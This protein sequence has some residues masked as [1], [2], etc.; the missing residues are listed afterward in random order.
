MKQYCNEQ[1]FV[2]ETANLET[3]DFV[4]HAECRRSAAIASVKRIGQGVCT[5][6]W[7]D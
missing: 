7:H 5:A 4:C 6:L 1:W 3:A 2:E